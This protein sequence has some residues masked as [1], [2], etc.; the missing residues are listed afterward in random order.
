MINTNFEIFDEAVQ[1]KE[2]AWWQMNLPSGDVTFGAAKNEMLGYPANKFKTYHDF[3]K[4]VHPDDYEPMMQAMRALLE[5]SAQA[6]ETTY[7]MKTVSGEY[8]TFFDFGKIINKA[9]GRTTVIGFVIKIKSIENIDEII[10]A[11]KNILNNGVVSISDLF[12]S[13]KKV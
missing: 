1:Q 3:T 7:R 10:T 9:D 4:L 11:F 2:I 6:Y 13:L 12:G 5:G 8:I